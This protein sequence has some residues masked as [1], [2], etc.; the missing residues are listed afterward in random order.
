MSSDDTTP[1]STTLPTSTVRHNDTLDAKI[2]S[3]E[4]F[5]ENAPWFQRWK[6]RLAT[7]YTTIKSWMR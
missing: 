5:D 3:M 7:T 4:T 6:S 2:I 1:H